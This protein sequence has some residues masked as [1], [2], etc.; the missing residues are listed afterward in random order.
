MQ[1]DSTKNPGF[2][3]SRFIYIYIIYSESADKYYIG[4]TN[5]PLRRLKEHNEDI[6][7][8]FTS[9]YRLNK[10]QIACEENY[11]PTTRTKKNNLLFPVSKKLFYHIS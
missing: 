2:G 10:I 11:R 3:S 5:D 9:H 7:N 1:H 6:K 8:C 4:N